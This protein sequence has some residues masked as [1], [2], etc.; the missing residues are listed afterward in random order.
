MHFP[1]GLRPQPQSA[2]HLLLFWYLE[3]RGASAELK[4]KKGIFLGKYW[5][6][7]SEQTIDKAYL[8]FNTHA[9]R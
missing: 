3:F 7:V 6:P 9:N 8:V 2:I 4:G 5:G 1:V